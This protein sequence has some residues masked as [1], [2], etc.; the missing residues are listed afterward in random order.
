MLRTKIYDHFVLLLGVFIMMGPLVVAFMHSAPSRPSLELG[1]RNP[2]AWTR[3]L[4][5]ELLPEWP[6][7]DELRARRSLLRTANNGPMPTGWP[8]GHQRC[9]GHK[10]QS[11][12]QRRAVGPAEAE[13]QPHEAAAA[14]QPRSAGPLTAGLW[15]DGR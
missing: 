15:P 9:T 11:Q 3:M 10:A 12:R 1:G 14:G 8:S 5:A 13:V 6:R 2:A 4:A 7:R